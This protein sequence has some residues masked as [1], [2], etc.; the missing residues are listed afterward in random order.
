MA[1]DLDNGLEFRERWLAA[2]SEERGVIG[3]SPKTGNFSYQ[4]NRRVIAGSY[5][6]STSYLEWPEVP[7][8]YWC[9]RSR[10]KSSTDSVKS[11]SKS[12]TPTIGD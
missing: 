1:I 4:P 11:R 5:D 12:K 2:W 10:R 3:D 6:R 9:S 7:S 8:V